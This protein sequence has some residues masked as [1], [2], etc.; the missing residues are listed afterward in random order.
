MFRSVSLHSTSLRT[1]CSSLAIVE[2]TIS[3][4]QLLLFFP[5]SMLFPEFFAFH[6]RSTE[7]LFG[8]PRDTTTQVR[9]SWAEIQPGTRSIRLSVRSDDRAMACMSGKAEIKTRG[10]RCFPGSAGFFTCHW[11]SKKQRI[12]AKVRTYM[13]GR[14][15]IYSSRALLVEL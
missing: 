5:S 11:R 2:H 1:S 13:I 9:L 4:L 3:S 12:V 14:I 7:L 6:V 10:Q 8:G 15:T